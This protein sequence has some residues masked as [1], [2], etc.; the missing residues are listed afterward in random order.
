VSKT[1]RDIT[2]DA[3]LQASGGP[4]DYVAKAEAGN[5]PIWRAAWIAAMT[6]RYPLGTPTPT[7]EA[8]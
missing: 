6:A 7:K 5:W 4:A 8:E 3:V 2:W 1:I